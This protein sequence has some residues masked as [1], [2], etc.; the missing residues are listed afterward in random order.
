MK[1]KKLH[2]PL[3][4]KL[5]NYCNANLVLISALCSTAQ[6]SDGKTISSFPVTVL[7]VTCRHLSSV[8]EVTHEILIVNDCNWI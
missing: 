5:L 3:W 1:L 4:A 6:G 8:R 7:T 2:G